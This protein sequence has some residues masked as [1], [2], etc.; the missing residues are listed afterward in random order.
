MDF[1]HRSL[2][3]S[4]QEMNDICINLQI[5]Q[6]LIIACVMDSVLELFYHNIIKI[7]IYVESL[8]VS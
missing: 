6:F 5:F 4:A 1:L 7:R 3:H 2:A 8:L